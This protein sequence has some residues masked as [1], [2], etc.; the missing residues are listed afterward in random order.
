MQAPLQSSAYNPQILLADIVACMHNDQTCFI[1]KTEDSRMKNNTIENENSDEDYSGLLEE[2]QQIPEDYFFP[3][4]SC[5][6]IPAECNGVN[7]GDS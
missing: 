3:T 4:N 6:G 1:K 5:D 2:L 7:W